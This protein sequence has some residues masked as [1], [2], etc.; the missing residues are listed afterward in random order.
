MVVVVMPDVQ[1]RWRVVPGLGNGCRTF[2]STSSAPRLPQFSTEHFR[3]VAKNT[4]FRPEIHRAGALES[5]MIGGFV[6]LEGLFA[7]Q[8]GTSVP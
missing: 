8:H 7:C 4:T 3:F 6:V 5:V 2:P 1:T